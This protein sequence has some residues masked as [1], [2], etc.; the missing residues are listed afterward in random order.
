MGDAWMVES[1]EQLEPLLFL[2]GARAEAQAHAFAQSLAKSIGHACV[3]IHDRTEVVV[4]TI[5]YRADGADARRASPFEGG[6]VI[7]AAV[8][9]PVRDAGRPSWR[10]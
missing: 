2:S 1:V 8:R 5:H 3:A 9:A 10:C 6:D 4:G 7:G